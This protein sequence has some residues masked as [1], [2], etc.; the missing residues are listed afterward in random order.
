MLIRT[1]DPK[2]IDPIN[3]FY[4]FSAVF[5]VFSTLT[6]PAQTSVSTAPF[7]QLPL[8]PFLTLLLPHPL[9][10]L[11]IPLHNLLAQTYASNCSLTPSVS[12]LPILLYFPSSMDSLSACLN[13]FMIRPHLPNDDLASG[14]DLLHCSSQS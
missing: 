1:E 3:W 7:S 10:F 6:N 2:K 9:P 14:L 8:L 5:S 4:R 13:R 12:S 11:R